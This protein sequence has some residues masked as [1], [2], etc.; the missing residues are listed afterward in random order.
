MARMTT[1]RSES[2]D[3]TGFQ[4]RRYQTTLGDRQSFGDSFDDYTAWLRP[5]LEQAHRLLADHGT[6]Y[7]HVD[8]R[9]VHYC[10]VL[11]DGIFGRDNFL[12]EVIWAYDY[13]GRSRRRWPA[14]HDN[15]LVYVKDR[16]RYVFNHDDLDRIPYMAPGLVTARRRRRE[17]RRPPTPGGRPSSPPTAASAPATR[18]R[19][20]WRSCRGS[21]APSAPRRHRA[22]LLRRLRHHRRGSR[23]GGAQ[24]RPRRQLPGGDQGG[25]EPLRPARRPVPASPEPRAEVAPAVQTGISGGGTGTIGGCGDVRNPVVA[26][27]AGAGSVDADDRCWAAMTPGS[28]NSGRRPK[29]ASINAPQ[30]WCGGTGGPWWPM[31]TPEPSSSTRISRAG[32]FP[33]HASLTARASSRRAALVTASGT[34]P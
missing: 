19:S 12:N 17:A 22:R 10:K 32:S 16:D 25:D 31:W 15:I 7:F 3:R 1:R 34:A 4:G 30:A 6:L 21:C 27:R 28:A 13:G 29:P 11:L 14:K 9:E 20:R 2:G 23:P 24:L 26:L 5:R 18:P 8:Y 33:G